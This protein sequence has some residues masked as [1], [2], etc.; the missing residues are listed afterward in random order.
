M[1]L[2]KFFHRAPGNDDR[3]LLLI[4]E[5]TCGGPTLMG[6]VMD[7]EGRTFLR[8]DFK[9]AHEAVAAFRRAAD[10]LRNGGYVETADTQYTLR[11]LAAAPQPKP[12]WQQGLDEL[13]L[14][15]IIEDTATQAALIDK[16]AATPAAGEPFYIWL[17]AR[18]RFASAPKDHGGALTRTED[19]RNALGARR[20]S[21]APFY[22]WSLRT[23]QVE[24]FIQDLLCELHLAAGDPEAGLEAAQHAHEVDG[25]Q[26]R[27][28]RI[29]WILCEYFPERQQEAF[30]QAMRYAEFGGYEAVTSLPA[31]ADH[32]ARRNKKTRPERGWRWGARS[33]PASDA[34]VRA[35]E[36]KLGI[37]LP[38]DYRRFLKTARRT[39]LLIRIGDST[40]ALRFFAASRLGKQRDDL[41]GFI[42]RTEKSS[43][44]AEAYFRDQYGVSLRDLVPV[45]E[46]ADLSRNIVIHLGK[47]ERFGWCYQWDHD[48]AWELEAAQPSFDDAL[49]RLTIGIEQRDRA[50]LRFLGLETD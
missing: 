14:S 37:A 29:A 41:F 49:A 21:K 24:A 16:L 42:T 11:K 30:D 6:F 27:G 2:A 22:I 8:Q 28:G 45:A 5:R 38:E 1:Y 43:A 13:M 50:V 46:P 32:V 17:R 40:T 47:G 31:Y 4:F 36:H 25:D 10:E 9:S 15:A 3:E 26:Y 33:E 12:A 7:G 19:A 18:H 23:L 39:E 34:T 48:G 44:K 20:A 35:V